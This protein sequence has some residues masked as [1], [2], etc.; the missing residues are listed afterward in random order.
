MEDSATLKFQ[1]ESMDKSHKKSLEKL[2]NKDFDGF[3][4]HFRIGQMQHGYAIDVCKKLD[5]TDECLEKLSGILD[6]QDI[7]IENMLKKTC[8]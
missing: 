8:K 7:D 4:N 2:S 6:N 1:L 5:G 3:L